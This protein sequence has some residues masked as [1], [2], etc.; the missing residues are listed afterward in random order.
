MTGHWATLALAGPDS[1]QVLSDVC[2]DLDT[3]AG[4]F[5]HLACRQGTVAGGAARVTRV[6]FSGELAYEI[7]VPSTFALHVWERLIE[8]GRAYG[9]TPYGTEAMHVLRAEK[10]Y[11]IVGRETD[12]S[13]SPEDLGLDWL[14]DARK[15]DPAHGAYP[16]LG[17]R[18]LRRGHL[19][20]AGRLTG[21]LDYAEGEDIT[22]RDVE[23]V[24]VAKPTA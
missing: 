15:S 21:T 5:P 9:I 19:R 2:G 3:T 10:G 6:S 4:D 18:G 23:L 12:G 17:L 20:A 14:I 22:A 16:F 13:V 11:I 8:A 24:P 7:S 1:R